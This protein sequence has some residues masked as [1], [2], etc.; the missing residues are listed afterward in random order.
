MEVIQGHK[1]SLQETDQQ[2]EV[3]TIGELV[4]QIVDLQVDL[5]Q[6]LVHKSQQALLYNL[7]MKF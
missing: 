3:D 1:I 5:V 2:I 7:E 6:V 4:L